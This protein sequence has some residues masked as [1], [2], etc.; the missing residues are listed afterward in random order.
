MQK[1]YDIAVLHDNAYSELVFDGNIGGSFLEIEGAKEVGIEFNSFS[2]TYSIPG[3]RIA[4]AIGNKYMIKQLKT[5]KSH[6][7]YGMFLPF[8]KV[9]AKALS[10][11][12]EY[13]DTVRNTYETRR[14]LLINGL[15]KIGWNI[16]MT[17]GSMFVWARIPSKYQS[18]I[19]FT[20]DLMEKT[21][22]IVVPGS[23]FGD[24]GEGF[25]RMALVQDEEHILKAIENI[26]N[27]DIVK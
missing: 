27:S 6:V 26:K 10:G 5:L 18:S 25:V 20:L 19:K 15:N 1:K 9:A 16:D 24:E 22:V 11:S 21:G 2:K 4:F 8:Q 17:A 14:N 7:D 13:I 3:C 12:R 23:S